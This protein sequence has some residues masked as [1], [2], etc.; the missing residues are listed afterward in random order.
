MRR[1]A[2]IGP[3]GAGKTTLAL[4]LGMILGTE[5]VQLD[6]LF[7][8]PGWVA[9]P[10]VEWEDIQRTALLRDAWIADT[11]SHLAMRQRFEAADTI[12]FLDL[13]PLVCAVRALRRRI[14]TRRLPRAELPDGCAPG[15][16]D[17]AVLR[18]LRYVRRYRREI[19][20][21]IL[22]ELERLSGQ[23]RIV[24]LRRPRQIR[25]F[26]QSVARPHLQEPPLATPDPV[27]STLERA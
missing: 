6:R 1:V 25:Q 7:W 17:Q 18:Y 27:P 23:R 10:L 5:L 9:T 12:V 19:R 21:Q 8:K 15:R 4:E 22:D 16:L 14:R 2:I 11:A 3:G 24:V 20:P 26:I 13:P